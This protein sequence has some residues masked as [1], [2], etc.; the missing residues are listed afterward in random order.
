[1]DLN[2]L[3]LY[4]WIRPYVKR[5]IEGPTRFCVGGIKTEDP[6]SRYV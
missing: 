1:M 4:P 2:G 5:L 6:A 3:R